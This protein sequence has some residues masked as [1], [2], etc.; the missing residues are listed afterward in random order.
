MLNAS[1]PGLVAAVAMALAGCVTPTIPTDTAANVPVTQLLEA[2]SSA[3]EGKVIVKRNR[4]VAGSICRDRVYLDG[5]PVADLWPGQKV[6]FTASLGE[7]ILGVERLGICQGQM[8]ELGA[9][10]WAGKTKVYLVD[11]TTN[12][13]YIFQE[14]AF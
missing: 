3:H 6:E 1:H 7:H 4:S 11:I 12:L 8:R 14:T 5:K 9:R 13:E 10:L 2:F